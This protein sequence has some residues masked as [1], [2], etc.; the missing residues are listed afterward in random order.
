MCYTT[1]S[2]TNC[3]GL[4]CITVMGNKTMNPQLLTRNLNP[5]QSDPI[6]KSTELCM[7]KL[8]NKCA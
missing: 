8:I 4:I 7:H 2:L 1:L 5:K 3:H 6:Y